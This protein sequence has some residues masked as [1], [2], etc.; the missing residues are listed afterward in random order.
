[1][2]NKFKFELNRSGVAELLK[3]SEM[4]N[5]VSECATKV[6]EAC[7]G[8]GSATSEEFSSETVVSGTRVVATVRADTPR[9]YYSNLKHN[10]LVKAM[11][12]IK[13]EAKE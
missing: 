13:R 10:T 5:I 2:A 3:G 11:S 7:G 9:A 1:M 12:S 6:Q 4:T 8:Y